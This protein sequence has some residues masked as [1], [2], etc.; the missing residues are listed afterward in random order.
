M[1]KVDLLVYPTDLEPWTGGPPDAKQKYDRLKGRIYEV[2]PIEYYTV[3]IK[4]GLAEG[5]RLIEERLKRLEVPYIAI[6]GLEPASEKDE[7]HVISETKALL[8]RKISYMIGVPTKVKVEVLR[9]P[10]YEEWKDP[11]EEGSALDWLW[12]AVGVAGAIAVP[13][14][15]TLKSLKN[16]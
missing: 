11:P 1:G 2:M 16:P 9:V 15:F 6:R 13:L 3:L 10:R 5:A 8:E 4:K 7:E 14:L 12:L